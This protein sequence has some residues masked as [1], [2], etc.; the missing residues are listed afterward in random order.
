MQPLRLRGRAHTRLGSRRWR[1]ARPIAAPPRLACL[2]SPVEVLAQRV[3]ILKSTRRPPM[4][5]KKTASFMRSLCL[6]EIEEEI[7]VPFPEPTVAEKET[8]HATLG[9][10]KAM[11]GT[12]EKELRAWDEK[13][14]MPAPFVQE[15]REAGLFSLVIP[16]AHGG[17]GFGATAYSR[18]LQE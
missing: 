5:D 4:I 15:L 14:E 17:L 1:V 10:L 6:G 9:T 13:G 11:L 18:V 8:L 3:M 16:E 2:Q 7:L 12:K